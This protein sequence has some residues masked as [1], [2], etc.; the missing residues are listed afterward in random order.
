M[1]HMY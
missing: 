1:T